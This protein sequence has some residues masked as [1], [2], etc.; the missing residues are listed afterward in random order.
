MNKK[1]AEL[2]ADIDSWFERADQADQAEDEL[3]GENR[4]GD[5]L[6][7]WVKDKQKRLEKIRQA[8]AELEAEAK[9]AAEAPPDPSRTKHEAAPT[10]VP[11]KNASKN[12]T[13]P[14]SGLV[15]SQNGFIQGY[16]CQAA[17]D[18]DSQVIVAQQVAPNGNDVHQMV[19]MLKQIRAQIGRQAKEISADAGY[20]SE[21]NLKQLSRR[22]IRAYIASRWQTNTNL[23]KGLKPP[24]KVQGY[25]R[26]MWQRLRRGGYRS[27][28]RFRKQVV[29]PV[30][31]QIKHARGFRQFLLRGRKKVSGEWSL[32]CTVH[33]LLKLAQAVG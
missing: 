21:Y 7:D 32:L 18:G 1:E 26:Q 16:N 9:A 31:G 15:K 28:Y 24:E 10:G 5:E 23:K 22:R 6:P 2:K 20:C 3:Y 13:D 4:R 29:E 25:T 12:F 30:F 19:P 27:R 8:K 11:K 33:N 14:D 17:V